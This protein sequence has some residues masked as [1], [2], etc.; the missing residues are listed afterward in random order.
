MGRAK[1]PKIDVRLDELAQASKNAEDYGEIVNVVVDEVVKKATKQ[2]DELISE[3]QGILKDVQSISLEDLNYYITYL[4]T[5][6]YFTTDR[7]EVV[8]I[9]MDSSS[10]I[11]KEKYDELYV[12]AIGKTIPDKESETRKLVMNETVIETAYK[13]AYKKVQS[14][15]EHADKVLA[16]LKRVHQFRLNDIELT[17]YNAKGVTLNARSKRNKGKDD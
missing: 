12:L 13:R 6:M 1:L 4:P 7:A 5:V 10:A 17:N 14:K 8:G 16:S 15:L 9:K 3:I 2:L 11:R